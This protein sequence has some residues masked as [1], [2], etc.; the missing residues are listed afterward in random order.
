MH[1]TQCYATIKN[2]VYEDAKDR[3]K[4]MSLT[5]KEA[6]QDKSSVISTLEKC[7]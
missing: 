6:I 3:G 5:V 2:Y 7:T 4:Y 1:A